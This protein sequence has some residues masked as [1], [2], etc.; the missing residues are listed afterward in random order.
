M[1]YVK[2]LDYEILRPLLIYKYDREEMHKQD[3][4]VEMMLNDGNMVGDAFGQ[5]ELA[6][7]QMDDTD[8]D[9]MIFRVST[10]INK[11]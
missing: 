10:I 3:E 5:L 7:T 4:V 9:E 6:D 1:F 8:K 11:Q 2:K